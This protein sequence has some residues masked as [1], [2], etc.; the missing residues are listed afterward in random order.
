MATGLL[1]HLPR[2]A[3]GL[4]RKLTSRRRAFLTW[5]AVLLVVLAL[6]FT[7]THQKNQAPKVLKLSF[8]LSAR[9]R[10]TDVFVRARGA[11]VYVY[12]AI[13]TN[14]D[15]NSGLKRQGQRMSH[16]HK[17]TDAPL[18]EPTDIVITILDKSRREP[19]RC[20]VA[21]ADGQTVMEIPARDFY[22]LNPET[23]DRDIY[24]ARQIVCSVPAATSRPLPSYLTLVTHSSC[25]GDVSDYTPILYPP[26]VH[27]ELAVCAKIAHSGGLDPGRVIEWFEMQ[28]LLGVDKV[29]IYD[30]GNPEVLMK[31]FRHYQ[32]IGMLDI[33]PYDLPGS[34]KHRK[35]TEDFKFTPQFLHDETLAVLECRV[36]LGGYEMILSHDLDELV[37]PRERASL[38]DVFKKAR[39]QSPLAAGFYFLTEFFITSW[40]PTNRD[41]TL[42]FTRYQR[43]TAVHR[44]CTKFVVFPQRVHTFLTHTILQKSFYTTPYLSPRDL[45]LHHYRKCPSGWRTCRPDTVVDNTMSQY[46]RDL[47]LRVSKVRKL[48]GM[49]PLQV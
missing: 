18:T 31:V 26:R 16:Q 17:A 19:F 43:C 29:V 39:Q 45:I 25:H 33:V 23:T 34:P 24:M 37:V 21:L 11:E 14:Y 41:S 20:C 35:L 42:T 9:D 3:T 40:A 30:L 36:R 1:R 27:N 46:T 4:A 2:A 10:S 5:G 15:F 47:E 13:A 7:L 32:E 48:T 28:R 6:Y 49:T 22:S 44:E 12:S 8:S 38:K